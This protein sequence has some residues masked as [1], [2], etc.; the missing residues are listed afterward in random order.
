MRTL[1]FVLVLGFGALIFQSCEVYPNTTSGYYGHGYY[2]G[3]YSDRDYY[4]YGYQPGGY[5]NGDYPDRGYY[6]YGYQPGGYYGG[7]GYGPTVVVTPGYRDYDHGYRDSNRYYGG[8]SDN[9]SRNVHANRNAEV[10]RKAQV[11]RKVQANSQSTHT[12]R[13]RSDH[14]QQ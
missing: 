11:K 2:N 1:F 4:G 8:E 6:G 13:S 3:D 12:N 7:G 14:R 5:Y 9:S 10:N